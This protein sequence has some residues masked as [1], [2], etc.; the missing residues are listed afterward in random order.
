[1]KD[2]KTEEEAV[3][4]IK[5]LALMFIADLCKLIATYFNLRLF[6]CTT[7]VT[8]AFLC[9]QRKVV[10][11]GLSKWNPCAINS[12][13]KWMLNKEAVMLWERISKELQ[14]SSL[15]SVF[16]KDSIYWLWG[17]PD[18]FTARLSEE[19]SYNCL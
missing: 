16:W 2:N 9:M 4:E 19:Q 8:F 12:A 13:E 10:F 14:T 18:N 17:N 15:P 5:F 11:W 6:V 1:M 7:S 3:R